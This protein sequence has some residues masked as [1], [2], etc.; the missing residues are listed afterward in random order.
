MYFHQMNAAWNVVNAGIAFL[1]YRGTLN[2]Q[3]VESL[4]ILDAMQRFYQLLLINAG[5][6]ILYISGGIW[7]AYRGGGIPF[8]ILVNPEGLIERYNDV[9]PTFNLE[10]VLEEAIDS[11]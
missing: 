9:R 3:Y 8:Y 2:N 5:L 11:K 4:D 10:E 6:D 1:G 7:L